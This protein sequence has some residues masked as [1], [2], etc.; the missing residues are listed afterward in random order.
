MAASNTRR[1]VDVA[2]RGRTATA[3]STSVASIRSV[4]SARVVYVVPREAPE[5]GVGRVEHDEVRDAADD[6]AA[7]LGVDDHGGRP[8]VLPGPGEGVRP[9]AEIGAQGYSSIATRARLIGSL[10]ADEVPRPAP[11]RASPARRRR[12]A[13]RTRRPC[14]SGCRSSST[15]AVVA[16]QVRGG[17][18]AGQARR[19]V[20][21]ANHVAA[22]RARPPADVDDPDLGLAVPVGPSRTISAVSSCVVLIVSHRGGTAGLPQLGEHAVAGERQLRQRPVASRTALARAGATGLNGAS[23]IDLAPSGPSGSCVRA[24]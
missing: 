19:H 10:R 1:P 14:S 5:L 11:A 13:A 2:S 24:K 3:R 23:L 20:P 22:V 15:S 9:L 17:Q 18:V 6:A 7:E 16:G 12:A 8:G 21:V 4:V